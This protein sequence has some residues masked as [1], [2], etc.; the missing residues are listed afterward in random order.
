MYEDYFIKEVIPLIDK[1]FNTIKTKEGRY[2]GGISAGGYAALHNSF[3]HQE[4][5]GKVGG[6]MPAIEL[7]LEK[8]DTPYFEDMSVWEKYDPITVAKNNEI[9]KDI[10]V[11]LDAGNEDEGHFYEGCKILQDILD[12]KQIVSQN[13]IYEGHHNGAYIISNLEKYLEFYNS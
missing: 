9:S 1:E 8:E 4:M 12:K 6:H 5:F 13:H 11:Y 3:R 2:I 10:K 7:T